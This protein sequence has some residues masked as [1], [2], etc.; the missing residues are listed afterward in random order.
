MTHGEK[1]EFILSSKIKCP[2]SRIFTIGVTYWR[3]GGTYPP[4]FGVGVPYPYF[5]GRMTEK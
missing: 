2:K 1:T 3:Y 5:F 4:L